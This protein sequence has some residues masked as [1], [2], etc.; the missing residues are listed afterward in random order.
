MKS[1]KYRGSSE[2]LRRRPPVAGRQLLLQ[3]VEQ[4]YC[5]LRRMSIR[6]C[7]VSRSVC[8][9][10]TVGMADSLGMRDGLR[11]LVGPNCTS[12]R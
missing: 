12:L 8:V 1:G 7:C 4:A 5:R 3:P 6:I 11:G 10:D 9:N 2:P